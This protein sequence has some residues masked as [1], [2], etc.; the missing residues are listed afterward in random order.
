MRSI[1]LQYGKHSNTNIIK[2]I[3]ELNQLMCNYCIPNIL[4]N[5]ELYIGYK[6]RVSY[7]PKPLPHP[8]NLSSTGMK[9]IKNK[10]I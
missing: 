8:I 4:S 9:S 10:L 1:F 6:H 3:K 7:L 2:Q 5:I